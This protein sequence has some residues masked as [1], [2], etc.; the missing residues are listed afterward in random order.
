MKKIIL[1]F[2]GYFLILLAGCMTIPLLLAL[3]Y[4]EGH[5]ARAFVV[6]ILIALVPGI[7]IRLT[8]HASLSAS[9]LKLR[10]SYFIVTASWIIASILGGSALRDLG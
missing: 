5:C 7:L 6:S 8:T 9:K 10:Y 2:F 4:G 3:V 1:G